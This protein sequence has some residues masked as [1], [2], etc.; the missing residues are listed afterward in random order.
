MTASYPAT[1]ETIR[2]AL[3]DGMVIPAHP[4]ALT[5]ERKLDERRQRALSRYYLD[6]G[7]GGLAVG[8]HTTEFAIH[9]PKIGLYKPV[10]RLAIETV[11]AWRPDRSTVMV[12]GI[13]GR[14]GQAVREAQLAREIG[15]DLGLISLGALKDADDAGLID[16]CRQV[17]EAMPIMGFYL[18]PAAGGRIL[19][20]AFWSQLA[21]IPNLAAIKIAPFNRYQTLAVVRGVAASGRAER[22]AL[23]TGNDD[24]I[25]VDLLTRYEIAVNGRTVRMSIA[26]G[27]LGH[28]AFWTRR[29]VEQH[30]QIKNIRDAAAIPAELLTLAAQVTE[31]NEAVFDPSHGFAGCISG[32]LYVLT[33]TGLLE[34]VRTIDDRERLS[35]GQ[36]EKIDRIAERYPHLTDEEFVK[37]NL[38]RWLKG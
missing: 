25:I 5:A 33:R 7:A 23:Y 13:C 34:T 24:A 20:E 8:V 12:A 16:H 15:Y 9:D 35:P 36:T 18:Q 29:A 4:L 6:A 31:A 14:T 21:E 37:Q 38:A 3:A 10:L 1:P 2:T 28:W 17:A 19:S 32:I 27:L 11:R 22:V 30:E 26:G